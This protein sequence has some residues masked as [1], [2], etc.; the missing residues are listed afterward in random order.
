MVWNW[1][2]ENWPHFTWNAARLTKAETLFAEQAGIL[3]GASQHL[4]DQDRQAFVIKSATDEAY[5]T[6]AIEGEILGRS[7]P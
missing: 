2:L 4:G 6:S 1:Q 7:N 3:V 5:D